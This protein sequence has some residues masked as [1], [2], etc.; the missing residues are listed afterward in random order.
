MY[1]F[2]ILMWIIPSII[3]LEISLPKLTETNTTA[4]EIPAHSTV[5]FDID[6]TENGT[7]IPT[8]PDTLMWYW[9][10]FPT[11]MQRH[12]TLDSRKRQ[13]VLTNFSYA[14][15][16]VSKPY[17]S[18][19][20]L[21]LRVENVSNRDQFAIL[22]IPV[23]ILDEYKI[24]STDVIILPPNTRGIFHECKLN[25]PA[26]NVRWEIEST[27]VPTAWPTTAIVI[28]P[29]TGQL[30]VSDTSL[31]YDPNNPYRI[32]VK[33]IVGNLTLRQT[34][35]MYVQNVTA[36]VLEIWTQPTRVMEKRAFSIRLIANGPP[37]DRWDILHMT[38]MDL[39]DYYSKFDFLDVSDTLDFS[40]IPFKP[41][42]GK[43]E[44]I[45][46]IGV[47]AERANGTIR[48]YRNLTLIV[49]NKLANPWF[50]TP[51]EDTTIPVYVTVPF[52]GQFLPA[53]SRLATIPATS[54]DQ[55]PITYY[56]ELSDVV[57]NQTQRDL[58]HRF[59]IDPATGYV[60][61]TRDLP[62][63]TYNVLVSALSFPVG[64]RRI[65]FVYT[66]VHTNKSTSSLGH[67]TW[68]MLVVPVIGG[69]YYYIKRR[70]A[71]PP[72]LSPKPK[73]E[74]LRFIIKCT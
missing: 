69:V 51:S 70:R 11:L 58:K 55:L 13:I 50:R 32:N 68:I 22:S 43:S 16:A 17:P 60:Y 21:I 52:T 25:R 34:I 73:P 33:A 3:G 56:L 29:H 38:P 61:T 41:A 49:E 4:L 39:I 65:Q 46:S 45:Y 15:F 71:T 59:R 47:S 53:N 57:L 6:V 10:L 63:G 7:L 1:H 8:E 18:G 44:N 35:L 24:A 14:D 20:Q 36:T 2:V 64:S 26:R 42:L 19:Y 40:P 9:M 66:L 37:V 54:P 12:A 27:G 62:P 31:T 30:S 74:T 48:A 67:L 28:D 5:T 72:P 23:T